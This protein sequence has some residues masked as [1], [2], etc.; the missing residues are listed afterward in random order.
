MQGEQ[1]MITDA[2]TAMLACATLKDEIEAVIRLTKP[3][4]K[5]RYLSV[6]HDRPDEMRGMIGRAVDALR[7]ARYILLAYGYCGGGL[8]GIG[9]QT[10]TLVIPK[11]HDCIDCLLPENHRNAQYRAG[12]YFLTGGWLRG[13]KNITREIKKLKQTLDEKRRADYLKAV[14]GGYRSLTLIDDGAYSLEQVLPLAEDAAEA[15]ELPV[16]RTKGSLSTIEKLITGNWDDDFLIVSPGER[17]T[18]E[19]IIR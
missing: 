13:E 2:R 8:E 17:I 14:Y 15:L 5:V 4:I 10:S 19:V 18:R 1:F 16:E 9:S 3:Q 11:A 12:R 6:M 7:D